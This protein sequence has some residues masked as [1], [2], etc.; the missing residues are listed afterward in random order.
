MRYPQVLVYERDGRLAALLKQSLDERKLKWVVREPRD[1]AS[2]L[3]LLERGGPSVVVVKMGGDLE[4]ELTLVERTVFHHPDT[5]TVLVGD[6]EHVA[7]AGAGW[8]LG[9]AYVLLP[10][11]SRESLPDIVA[12]LMGTE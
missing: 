9:A 1:L 12:G 10:P 7:L 6:G 4:R 5:K 8:D 11:M 2:C 3:R